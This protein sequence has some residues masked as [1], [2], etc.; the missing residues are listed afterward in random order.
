MTTGKKT[1]QNKYVGMC[2]F[3]SHDGNVLSGNTPTIRV[4]VDKKRA[5]PLKIDDAP[6]SEVMHFETYE[7]HTMRIEGFT[8]M[9]CIWVLEGLT[10]ADAMRHI[11]HTYAEAKKDNAQKLRTMQ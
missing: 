3:G 6:V 10:L 2:I 11:F 9:V 5:L 1:I 7:L 8:G 4:I